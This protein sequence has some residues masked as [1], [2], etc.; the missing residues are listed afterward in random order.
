MAIPNS[1]SSLLP[2]FYLLL[3]LPTSYLISYHTMSRA[4][5]PRSMISSDRPTSTSDS[6]EIQQCFVID[7]KH[8][9]EFL[10]EG[11]YYN[12]LLKEVVQ[13]ARRLV[14]S[15]AGVEFAARRLMER[16]GTASGARL[17]V[18]EDER[19]KKAVSEV[20]GLER[21]DLM[22]IVVDI[23]MKAMS[24][25]SNHTVPLIYLGRDVSRPTTFG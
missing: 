16:D 13:L 17:E 3:A 9:G 19:L 18:D 7:N 1:S 23:K 14:F 15:E 8:S 22:S 11:A 20:R 6:G 12:D 4:P 10:I 24:Q 21:V 5:F 25:I 2:T